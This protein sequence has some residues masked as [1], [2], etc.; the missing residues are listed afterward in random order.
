MFVSWVVA[1]FA[2][3]NAFYSLLQS[4]IK[5]GLKLIDLTQK[6]SNLVPI[7]K[8]EHSTDQ[9]QLRLAHRA[10]E[11]GVS[12]SLIAFQRDGSQ[13]LENHIPGL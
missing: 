7:Y 3:I 1:P 6:K 8:L 2:Q 13:V 4:K 12:S 9:G 10:R 11:V 5:F